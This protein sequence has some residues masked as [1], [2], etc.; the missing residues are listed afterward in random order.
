MS[1]ISIDN[2]LNKH[3]IEAV[4]C[5]FLALPGSPRE[6]RITSSIPTTFRV[7]WKVGLKFSWFFHA[8]VL[9]P[10]SLWIFSGHLEFCLQKFIDIFLCPQPP[11][12]VD[13]ETTIKRYRLGYRLH[14]KNP[15]SNPNYLDIPLPSTAR[16]HVITGLREYTLYDIRLNAVDVN[17]GNLPS[18]LETR[19][20]SS[21]RE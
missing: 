13:M 1:G 5:C 15:A 17:E 18:Y 2:S 11:S 20:T 3:N 7:T 14:E 6:V 8:R 19:R 16:S 21:E 9:D 10:P 12:L 4:F